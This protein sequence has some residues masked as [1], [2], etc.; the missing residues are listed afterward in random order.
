MIWKGPHIPHMVYVDEEIKE[1][2]GYEQMVLYAP[3]KLRREAS[4]E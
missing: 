3:V 4:L 2:L 1:G